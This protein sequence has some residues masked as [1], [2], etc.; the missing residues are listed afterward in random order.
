MGRTMTK[1]SVSQKEVT[2]ILPKTVSGALVSG[3]VFITIL[4]IIMYPP[5]IPIGVILAVLGVGVY[6]VKGK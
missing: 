3:G 2:V 4:G 6:L 1:M 5:A